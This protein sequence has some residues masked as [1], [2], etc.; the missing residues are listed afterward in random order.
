VTATAPA[1]NALRALPKVVLHDHLDGG[2]RPETVV[3]LAEACG[4]RLPA[5]T[6]EDVERW[7]VEAAAT[8]SLPRFLE[9]FEHTVAVMQTEV[10]LARVARE[11][12]VDLARDGVVYAEIRYAP[13]LHTAGGLALA[14]VAEAVRRGLAEGVSDA[15]SEGLDIEAGA[16]LTAMRHLSA[17]FDVAQLAAE[18]LGRCC[19]GFD[20]A[21][22]EVGYPPSRHAAAFAILRE[23]GVPTSIHAGEAAGI[24]S[25]AEAI[26]IGGARR[27]AHGVRVADDVEWPEWPRGEPRVGA[28]ASRVRDGGIVLEACPTS[29]VLTG[30][31]RSVASNPM[32]LLRDAGFLVTVNP[33]DRLMCA[34][35]ATHESARLV[36]EA[37]WTPDDIREAN[38]RA[39]RAIFQPPE[40]V[41][42][43]A[44][45]V[46]AGSIAAGAEPR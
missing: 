32:T 10:A 38:L 39:A 12:V 11:A 4:H 20:L 9:T 41:A 45:R 22:P 23:A 25:V 35:S 40:V 46:A 37:G 3:D 28:V 5:R 31:A 7:F 44:A 19:V 27:L 8:G 13:E 30:V 29:N 17:S 36:A 16:L 21:G 1:T 34:T 42:R 2:L 18:T 24:D 15:R 33:D 6:P 26:D 14:D 43:I